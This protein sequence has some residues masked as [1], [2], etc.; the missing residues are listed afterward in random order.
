VKWLHSGSKQALFCQ[1]LKHR[2]IIRA[3]GHDVHEFL[4]GLITND[5][6]LLD[7]RRSTSALYS[8]LLNVEGRVLCDL[9]I[10]RLPSNNLPTLAIECCQD[11]AS[12][13]MVTLSRY[14]LRRKIDIVNIS[15][16][17]QLHTVFS[18]DDQQPHF[19]LSHCPDVVFSILDP[20][21]PSLGY[22]LLV[23]TNTDVS[24]LIPG[25]ENSSNGYDIKRCRLG[26]GEGTTD[27]PPGQ[28]LPL[29]CNIELLNGVS[30]DKGCY[31]GQEL[32]AR[33]RYTGVIRKR[34]VPLTLLS[35]VPVMPGDAIVNS[36]GKDCGKVRSVTGNHALGL[37]RI[38]ELIKKSVL[39]IHNGYHESVAVS[40]SVPP[41]WQAGSDLLLQQLIHS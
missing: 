10:Y 28:C 23:S 22:R 39:H 41:W 9:I 34:I 37:L 1:H 7:N 4:Q 18:A 31:I 33:S 12:N 14:R 36:E 38:S 13:L 6:S 30:F 15:N 27:F 5:V 3:A 24:A 35:S 32:T 26:V 40:A 16:D 11:V 19:S 25:C 8:M 17:F 29:E 2:S 21:L 20:R